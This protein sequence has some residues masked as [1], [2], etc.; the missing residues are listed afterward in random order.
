MKRQPIH[1][2]L[3][4]VANALGRKFGVEVAIGGHQAGTNGD[5]IILPAS[6]EAEESQVLWGYLA[7]E[8][9]HVRYTDFGSFK[10]SAD[11]PLRKAIL[12][13]LEDIRIE[14]AIRGPFPGT[15]LSI[16]KTVEAM[17]RRGELGFS[18]SPDDKPAAVLHN[19]LLH[20]L[21]S[22]LLGQILLAED[23]ARAESAMRELFPSGVMTRLHGLLSEVPGL[24]STREALALTDRILR[25]I[26]EE[27]EKPKEDQ[28]ASGCPNGTE[29]EST[30]EQ[31]G[32][33]SSN[34]SSSDEDGDG[35]SGNDPS[36][37]QDADGDSQGR[38]AEGNAQADKGRDSGTPSESSFEKDRESS[39]EGDPAGSGDGGGKLTF[40]ELAAAEDD[41]FQDPFERIRKRME[42]AAASGRT[43]WVFPVAEVLS[44]RP[45][46]DRTATLK[47][48]TAKLRA[49]LQGMVQ[50]SRMQR[51]WHKD[52]G[53]RIDPSRLAGTAVGNYRVFVHRTRKQAPDTAV[54]LLLDR[55]GSM[56]SRIGTAIDAALSLAMALDGIPGVNPAVT[57]FP[58]EDWNGSKVYVLHRHGADRVER[59]AS[60]F[61]IG[62]HGGTP[63]HTALWYA[64]SQVLACREARKVILVVTD[65][66]PNDESATR[67]II[68]RCVLSGIEIYGVGIDTDV[69]HL[70][71]RATFIERVDELN[72]K[73]FDL[74]RDLLTAA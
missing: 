57:A 16:G 15:R 46:P 39:L 51:P 1:R 30:S 68:E 14:L 26:Q 19:Y 13:I 72:R 45:D 50:A 27:L 23:A 62:A 20:R 73:L 44:G 11:V 37:G 25:M 42:S 5:V 38:N 33:G 48:R 9:A 52:R 56:S 58:A 54:H 59:S 17:K 18:Y 24:M 47:R 74:S 41:A 7:H 34:H 60:A 61:R 64:A 29:P 69:G 63:L 32:D 28:D 65:G 21:R 2:A 55:S 36:S 22:D 6:A 43:E 4:I 10:Q 70:F 35:Q 53:R 67:D 12:N 3:P 31:D 49:A 71:K 40:Q 66:Q 8:A